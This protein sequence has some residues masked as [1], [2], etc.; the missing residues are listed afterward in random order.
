MNEFIVNS[1][2]YDMEMEICR[3]LGVGSYCS[4]YIKCIDMIEINGDTI[5]NLAYNLDLAKTITEDPNVSDIEKQIIF[6]CRG[7]KYNATKEII[8]ARSY[9]GIV[10]SE[11]ESIPETNYTLTDTKGLKHEIDSQ[12]AE[13]YLSLS[14]PTL[15]V[16]LKDNQ[17]RYSTTKKID[18]SR[19]VWNGS[20]P[21]LKIFLD[22]M[23]EEFDPRSL[24]NEEKDSSLTHVFIVV[25]PQLNANSRLKF[26][27]CVVYIGSYQNTSGKLVLPVN[28]CIPYS[29]VP[30]NLFS[31]PQLINKLEFNNNNDSI[32]IT[33]NMVLQHGLS[34]HYGPDCIFPEWNESEAVFMKHKGVSYLLIPPSFK[35]R[36]ELFGN[37]SGLKSIFY[38]LLGQPDKLLKC[39][40]SCEKIELLTSEILKSKKRFS[41]ITSYDITPEEEDCNNLYQIV[42]TNLLMAVPYQ[43]IENVITILNSFG[44]D[45]AAAHKFLLNNSN[46]IL[47]SIES[48][49]PTL[50]EQAGMY[51]SG[52]TK[53]Y[54]LNDTGK[55]FMANFTKIREFKESQIEDFRIRIQQFNIPALSLIFEETISKYFYT[56][57]KKHLASIGILKFIVS[58]SIT[59]IF[60]ITRLEHKFNSKIEADRKKALSGR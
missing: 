1:I 50:W 23:G 8:V 58:A 44:N 47:K 17:I 38:N 37:G 51:S 46:N 13:H 59:V 45:I 41:Q 25:S 16:W 29:D 57:A 34:D 9:P 15:I 55:Y 27:S 7:I 19:S 26:N 36:N 33:P 11:M 14:G 43:E 30:L 49:P 39:G 6:D 24:F 53:P 18:A 28:E 54:R 12:E 52:K 5:L 22:L 56:R 31:E 21:F 4:R 35:Y 3:L 32:K 48:S 2:G 60:S 10:I 40:F 20:E 42:A